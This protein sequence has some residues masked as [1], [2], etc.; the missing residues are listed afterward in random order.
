M[1]QEPGYGIPLA[2]MLMEIYDQEDT[3]TKYQQAKGKFQ[4]NVGRSEQDI[5]ESD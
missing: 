5:A 2:F 4:K 3:K 1:A